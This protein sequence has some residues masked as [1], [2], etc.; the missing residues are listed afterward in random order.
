MASADPT[1]D[2][3]GRPAIEFALDEKGSRRFALL[4]SRA[5]GRNLAILID[6]KIYAAPKV[7]DS[8]DGG[9]GIISG[10]FNRT[11]F[12]RILRILRN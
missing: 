6:D 9:R 3:T 5:V 11:Q 12:W 2:I 4:T 1:N 10:S 8:M 7:L